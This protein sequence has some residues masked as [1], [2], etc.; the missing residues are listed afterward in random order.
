MK[1]F[2]AGSLCLWQRFLH[3]E[4]SRHDE[5][6]LRAELYFLETGREDRLLLLLDIDGFRIKEA[7]LET[8]RSPEGSMPP[9]SLLFLQGENVYLK[10]ARQ[11]KNAIMRWGQTKPYLL[12]PSRQQPG[13][14]G[15]PAAA[16]PSLQSREHLAALVLELIPNIIQG[17]PSIWAQ[18]GYS[19]LDEHD[20]HFA[21]IFGEGCVL[22]SS[23]NKIDKDPMEAGFYMQGQKRTA[24]LFSRHRSI[25]LG[26]ESGNA[27]GESAPGEI[28]VGAYLCDSYHEMALSLKVC[29]EKAALKKGSG[30]FLRYPDP[31]CSRAMVVL[32]EIAGL[33]LLPEN[34]KAIL[35]ALTGP[36]GCAHLGDLAMD[37]AWA[38]KKF[39]DYPGPDL[40]KST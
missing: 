2:T 18:R 28:T 34:R 38:L 11:L 25:H 6:S 20:R 37:A 1:H 35:S 31:L 40:S 39:R 15:R 27:A 16:I 13:I 14:P 8:P 17:E 4:I 36:R 22:Y 19:S 9:L 26:S 5:R 7:L 29:P 30:N 32:P 33:T 12:N 24:S 3:V 21:Q 23:L 10:G